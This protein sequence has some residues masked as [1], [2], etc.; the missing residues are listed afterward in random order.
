MQDVFGL[1]VGLADDVFAH[2]LRVDEG[3]LE[4]IAVGLIALH[5]AAQGL[6]LGSQDQIKKR[7][8]SAHITLGNTDN[9]TEIRL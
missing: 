8:S 4:H 9:K 7:H 3:T 6:V 5:I 2:A 1:L